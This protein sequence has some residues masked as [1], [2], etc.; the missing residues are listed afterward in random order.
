MIAKN[1]M[2]L[3]K[4]D[5]KTKMFVNVKCKQ[6]KNFKVLITVTSNQCNEV[7]INNQY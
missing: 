5:P 2:P 1:S 4:C 7:L 6:R 3:M